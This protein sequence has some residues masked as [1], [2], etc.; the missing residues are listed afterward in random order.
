MGQATLAG[1]PF[2]LDPN[3]VSWN[4][5]TKAA[6]KPTVGG[7]VIQVYGTQ[8]SD[9]T[10]TG[11]FGVGGWQQQEAFL[12]EMKEMGAKQARVARLSRSQAQPFRFTYPPRGWEFLVY[13]K[14]YSNPEGG[15]AVRHEP[16]I[17]NPKWQLTL[18]IVEDNSGLK[19][20]AQNAYIS[21]LVKGMGWK[22]TDFN[23][24][25]DFI[26]VGQAPVQ[27]GSG[28]TDTAGG[29]DRTMGNQGSDVEQWRFLVIK[30][31]PFNTE[32]MMCIMKYESGGNPNAINQSGSSAMGLFQVMASVWAE[33]NGIEPHHL[34]DPETNVRIAKKIYDQQG[35]DAWPNTSRKCR[36]D[37]VI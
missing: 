33:P 5:S 36:N 12:K 10:I 23:G 6:D 1:R 17:F 32:Q 7:K 9:M 22:R 21:R 3:S 4:F 18:F 20:V 24:P 11:E 34:Y 13:L 25:V 19:L 27:A 30:H 31:F 14:A 35:Y 28:T 29:I 16:G 37:G 8:I 15:R 26:P 2:R